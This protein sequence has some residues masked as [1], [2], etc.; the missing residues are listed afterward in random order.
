MLGFNL[1][2]LLAGAPLRMWWG[3][4]QGKHPWWDGASG[5]GPP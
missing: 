3:G 2:L 1:G 5:L 4:G